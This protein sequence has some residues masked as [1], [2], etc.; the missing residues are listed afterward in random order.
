MTI[1]DRVSWRSLNREYT[2]VVTGFRRDFAV[3]RIDG[4]EKSVLLNNKKDTKK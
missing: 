1:G 4:S 3:V 2:G